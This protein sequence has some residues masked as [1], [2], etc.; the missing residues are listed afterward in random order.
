ML[1]SRTIVPPA[2][3]AYSDQECS[4][5]EIVEHLLVEPSTGL[6]PPFQSPI[7]KLNTC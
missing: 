4:L 5:H 6:L 7:M 3:E 2:V 1:P